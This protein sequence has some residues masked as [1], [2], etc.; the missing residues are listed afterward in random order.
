MKIE[1]Y[2]HSCFKITSSNYSIVLDPYNPNMIPGLNKLDLVANLVLASHEHADHNYKKAV[3]IVEKQRPKSIEINHIDSFHD[4]KKGELRGKN[5]I[6]IIKDN[7]IKLAHLGDLGCKLNKEAMKKLTKL[8]VLLIPVG[9]HFTIDAKTAKSICDTLK[10][11]VIIPMHYRSEKFGFDILSKVEEFTKLF[12]Q[13]K[14][15]NYINNYLE[16][17][18]ST[19]NQVAI[20]K[21][22]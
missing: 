12:N 4:N 14:I 3:K 13:E 19:N 21:T 18:N 15:K 17:S 2:G 20:F 16:I 7:N 10:P 1:W 11:K 8:D 6:T 9:G 5:I 22:K